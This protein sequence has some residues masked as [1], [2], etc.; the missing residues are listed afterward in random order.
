LEAELI[1]IAHR[2]LKLKGKSDLHKL[3]LE[4]Q[5]LYEKL[6]VLRFV[7]E[8]FNETQPT[9]GKQAIEEKLERLFSETPNFIS[10]TIEEVVAPYS[11]LTPMEEPI[12]DTEVEESVN[13]KVEN[14]ILP[15]NEE[16][17]LMTKTLNSTQSLDEVVFEPSVE[18][19]EEEAVTNLN[20]F[21][22]ADLLGHNYSEPVFV[23]VGEAQSETL[24]IPN[25]ESIITS[26]NEID[27]EFDYETEIAIVEDETLVAAVETK[28]EVESKEIQEEIVIE[29]EFTKTSKFG[30]ITLNDRLPKLF[31]FGL[32]D[33]IG[34]ENQLFGG[35][36]EDF[37]RVLSQLSTYDTFVEAK[38]FIEQMVKP[39]YNN[40]EGK[41]DFEQRFLDGI[42]KAFS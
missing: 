30:P 27:Y 24:N 20:Q 40:W 5:K 12:G 26:E 25:Q 42:E 1:S 19:I 29:E 14:S 6:S 31:S 22:F 18:T 8:N 34:F 9:I 7:E 35:S 10:E 36:N 23:K 2:I 21:S 17:D 3:H 28:E 11:I 32:N 16:L 15:E 13:E 4:T 38:D 39:D 33:R 37:N 41:D